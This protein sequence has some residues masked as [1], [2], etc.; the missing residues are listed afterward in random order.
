MGSVRAVSP[1]QAAPT[2]P[3][4][5]IDRRA[6]HQLPSRTHQCHLRPQRATTAPT[7]AASCTQH[8]QL[9]ARLGSQDEPFQGVQGHFANSCNICVRKASNLY[10]SSAKSA[11]ARNSKNGRGQK[12]LARCAL[13]APSQV[14]GRS[15]SRASDWFLV[16]SALTLLGSETAFIRP[17]DCA[18]FL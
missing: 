17:F 16:E 8:D 10:V 12:S 13:R 5:A 3:A 7:T 2:G 11:R 9:R 6:E 4:R 15:S 18:T 1:A 14:G